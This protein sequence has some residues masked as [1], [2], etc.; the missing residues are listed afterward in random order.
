MEK[1]APRARRTARQPEPEPEQQ[2]E[3]WGAPEEDEGEGVSYR[4]EDNDDDSYCDVGSDYSSEAGGAGTDEFGVTVIDVGGRQYRKQK[5]AYVRTK[6]MTWD[7]PEA[8]ATANGQRGYG[9]EPS[10]AADFEAQTRASPAQSRASPAQARASP[11]QSRKPK[12]VQADG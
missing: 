12:R 1:S 11:A 5:V 2:F 7:T 8:A 3:D 4:D 6:A 10:C 9:D